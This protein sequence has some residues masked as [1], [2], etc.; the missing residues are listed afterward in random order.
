MSFSL[1]YISLLTALQEVGPD[2]EADSWTIDKNGIDIEHVKI[3]SLDWHYDD[4]IVLIPQ[5][6]IN[7]G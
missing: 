5:L 7:F 1:R 3:M 4:A 6:W 2:N